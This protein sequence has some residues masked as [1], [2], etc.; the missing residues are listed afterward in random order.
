VA[1]GLKNRDVAAALFVSTKTVEAH[2]ARLYRK[3][4]IRSRAELARYMA[5]DQ[6]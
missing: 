3:L 2:L 5:N 6:E 4:K 1:S